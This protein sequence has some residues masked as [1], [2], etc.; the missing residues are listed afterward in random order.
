MPMDNR[1]ILVLSIFACVLHACPLWHRVC[2]SKQ[3][4]VEFVVRPPHPLTNAD[5]PIKIEGFISS[6]PE[7][8]MVHVSSICELPNGRLA[9]VWYGGSREGGKDGLKMRC[10]NGE[11][12]SSA[13]PLRYLTTAIGRKQ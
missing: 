6:A 10:T 3:D 2:S 13:S 12:I 4:P 1:I 5:T 11:V 9:A 8:D 7:G